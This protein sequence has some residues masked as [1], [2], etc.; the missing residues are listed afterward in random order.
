M[1]LVPGSFA[2]LPKLLLLDRSLSAEAKVLYGIIASW[3]PNKDGGR[4]NH[5]SE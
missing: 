5:C 2:I 3:T 1:S 4:Y